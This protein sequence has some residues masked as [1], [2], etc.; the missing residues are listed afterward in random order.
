MVLGGASLILGEAS[1]VLGEASLV[2]GEASL[3]LGEASLVLGEASL[4]LGEAS[5]VLGEASLVLG[6]ASLVLGETS[7]ILGEASTVMEIPAFIQ[8]RPKTRHA[9]QGL[10]MECG[11]SQLAAGGRMKKGRDDFAAGWSGTALR[12]E[13]QPGMGTIRVPVA[14]FRLGWTN[15]AKGV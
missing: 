5:L 11:L 12:A 13:P 15:G 1:L 10:G 14:P 3:V 4:V 2:L 6:G 8:N 9:W 7:L